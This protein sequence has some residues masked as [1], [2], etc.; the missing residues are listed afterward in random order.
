MGLPDT[1]GQHRPVKIRVTRK[2][3]LYDLTEFVDRHPGGREILEQHN[4]LDIEAA[5]QNSSVHAHSKA[6]YSMLER[7]A[8][9]TTDT[10]AQQ[11]SSA[12]ISY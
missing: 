11:V 4:G 7:Y 9:G 6:A 1:N 12:S 8:V 3:K 5:M 2:G 10:S